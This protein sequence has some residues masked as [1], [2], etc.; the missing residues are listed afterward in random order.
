M[1][2]PAEVVVHHRS[3]QGDGALLSDPRIADQQA[4]IALVGSLLHGYH[5]DHAR[6]VLKAA[7]FTDPKCRQ[8]FAVIGSMLGSGMPVDPVTVASRLLAG[9]RPDE[10]NGMR[11][12]VAR[13]FGVDGCP[14]PGN[15]EYLR[16]VLDM[17]ARRG[18]DSS[19][20]RLRHFAVASDSE[21]LRHGVRGVMDDIRGHLGRLP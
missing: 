6:E 15:A 12:F 14:F 3:S 17:S 2:M 9:L 8:A 5:R 10:V 4:E 20:T 13:A 18:L 7:D 21:S 16:I 1:T 11:V 19:A